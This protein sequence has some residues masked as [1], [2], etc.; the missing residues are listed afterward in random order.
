MANIQ[1]ERE[2]TYEKILAVE[3]VW[4]DQILNIIS[5]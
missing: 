4:W 5:R 2:L 3:M 1:G